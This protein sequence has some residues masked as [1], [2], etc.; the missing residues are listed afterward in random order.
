MQSGLNPRIF[1]QV[2][3]YTVGVASLYSL[4]VGVKAEEKDKVLITTTKLLE[5]KSKEINKL[6]ND[7]I[8]MKN[9]Y[10]ASMCR[11]D[12]IKKELLNYNKKDLKF[13]N[14][15]SSILNELS[16]KNIL[17]NKKSAL[18]KKL[19]ELNL[20]KKFNEKN[21]ENGLNRLEKELNEV[22]KKFG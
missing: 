21:L 9:I 6:N 2:F 1:K 10:T 18:I 15:E 20:E 7:N 13:K 4:F 14:E 22:S 3:G 5:E 11:L 8:E 16:E 19:E 17:E 12:E